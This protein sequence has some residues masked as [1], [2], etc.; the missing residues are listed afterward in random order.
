MKYKSKNTG[1]VISKELFDQ[2]D[3]FT[4]Q[5]SED[6]FEPVYEVGDYVWVCGPRTHD[7][8]MIG[9]IIGMPGTQS[10]DDMKFSDSLEGCQIELFPDLLGWFYQKSI[11]SLATPKEI[12]AA[13]KKFPFEYETLTNGKNEFRVEEFTKGKNLIR[14]TDLADY[15]MVLLS[16]SAWQQIGIRKGWTL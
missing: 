10:Y 14:V 3:H 12:E 16:E 5:S 1:E 11:I 8:R 15:N 6:Y 13:Q 9:K 2:I 7:K 4:C